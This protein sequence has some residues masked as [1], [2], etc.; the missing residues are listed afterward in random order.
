MTSSETSL[1]RIRFRIDVR[2]DVLQAFKR[3]WVLRT[4]RG[5]W[6]TTGARLRIK[7]ELLHP[8][9][10]CKVCSNS[11]ELR[12]IF[13]FQYFYRVLTTI[14]QV[15]IIFQWTVY[16]WLFWLQ[17]LVNVSLDGKY[18]EGY[19]FDIRVK[20]N[21]L[22]HGLD[23]W[24]THADTHRH[25]RTTCF[26]MKK[27]AQVKLQWSISFVHWQRNNGSDIHY[28]KCFLFPR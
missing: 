18:A 14:S 7:S 3:A 23:Q 19:L 22:N 17:I 13:F 4:L 10:Q 1:R 24:C 9:F 26:Q 6:T 8:V 15:T 12:Y 2:V 25:L 16:R 21:W 11:V 27:N 28:H 20:K 5:L